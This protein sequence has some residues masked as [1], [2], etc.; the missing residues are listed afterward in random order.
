MSHGSRVSIALLFPSL[1]LVACGATA[2]PS[3]SASTP[4]PVPPG[5]AATDRAASMPTEM[6]ELSVRLRPLISPQSLFS[7]LE[8]LTNIQPYSGWRSSATTGESEA[9]D[10]VANTLGDMTYLRDS[11]MELER[12]SF[13][14]FVATELW[15]NRLYLTT[16]GQESEVPANAPRGH[17]H[18][19]VQALRFDSDG[20]LNDAERNPVEV[21]GEVLLIRSSGEIDDLSES[22]ARGKIVFLDSAVIGINLEDRLKT[23]EA[24]WEIVTRLTDRGIAGLVVVT[25]FSAV[26]MGTQGKLLGDGA[27]FEG[28]T[29]ERIVPTLYVRLEDLASAGISTWEDLAQV[30]SARLV[31]DADVFS[32]GTSGNLAARIPGADSSQAVI[33]GAHIDSANSPGAMDNGINAAALLEVARILN[34]SRTPPPADLYLVWFGSEELGLCG[35]QYFVDTHQELLD[36]T[37]AAFV[38]DGIIVSTPSS[39]LQLDGWSYSRFGNSAL[40]FPRHLAQLAASQGITIDAVEDVQGLSSDNSVFSGFVAQAGFAFGSEQGDYAHSPYDDV[41]TAQGLGDLMEQVTAVALIAAL[42]T[43]PNLPDL[44]VTPQPDRRALIVASHTEVVQ[45]TPAMLVELDR[46]LAWEGFDVDVIPNGQAVT[47][48]D[49]ADSDLVVLLPV[50]DYPSPAGDPTV[51]D[52][53]WTEP[54]IE[55]LVTYVEQGGLLVLTNSANRIWLGS[56]LDSNE[57]WPDMNAL[58]ESFDVVF[59]EGPVSASSARIQQAHPLMEDQ[60]GLA[61]LGGNAVAFTMQSGD[62]LAAVGEDPVVG[63][64]HW[65][66]AGGQVLVLADVGILGLAG[67]APEE[68]NLTFMRNLARYARLGNQQST[69]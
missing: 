66:A 14:V 57:D 44:R 9:L 55:S 13:P 3:P 27:A 42:D 33:L 26:P 21:A 50:I 48:A 2:T 7:F 61:L 32:P 5:P 35:S 56:L 43:E 16:K 51:Y 34:E 40:A 10:Y 38:M 12:Q 54:E 22:D 1:V 59:K 62:T 31:W 67:S 58:S 29:T 19:V 46:A 4:T 45:M 15:E 69:P 28:V 68:E 65:G 11:G 53:A 24:S 36:R 60:Y 41:Q 47:S 30:D 39:R 64:V 63:L 52:E 8:A 25:R 49:L 23:S 20:L 17:R 6:A 18:D 37:S